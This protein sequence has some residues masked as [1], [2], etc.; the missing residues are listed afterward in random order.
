MSTKIALVLVHGILSDGSA[1]DQLVD[2][3]QHD[4]ALVDRL[5]IHRVEYPTKL[6]EWKKT[7]RI[8]DI[9]TIAQYLATEIA[10]IP[11]DQPVVFMAHSQGGL[12]VQRFLAQ[13]LSAG[14]GLELA[15]VKRFM[16]FATP[17][18][19]SQF[20]LSIRKWIRNPQEE[21]LRP[22]A[23]EIT[24][25]QQRILD[26]VVYARATTPSTAPIPIEAYAGLSD[27]IVRPQ[28]ALS[29]FP[30]GGVLPGDHSTLIR[31][32]D[33]G[34]VFYRLVKDRLIAEV[35]RA[36]NRTTGR[37]N[38]DGASQNTVATYNLAPAE[39]SPKIGQVAVR[40]I[41]EALSAIPDLRVAATRRQLTG[42]MSLYVQERASAGSSGN[43][44]L[45]IFALVDV[46]ADMGD[47]GR[48][49]L[50]SSLDWVFGTEIVAVNHAKTVIEQSWPI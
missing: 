39:S 19:G 8:P 43:T 33:P 46:C 34:A 21:E 7:R 42:L 29:L 47:A 2:H 17:N 12:I 24:R 11:D 48:S 30:E 16:M 35:D 22:L 37:P 4:S 13:Q 1:W 44:R 27:R 9:S 18:S 6:M 49:E 28:S 26:G 23:E 20:L 32:Q 36:E 5:S 50:L 40:R 38:G 14:K 31:P 45:E 10:E 15:R 25:T 3:V 41:A